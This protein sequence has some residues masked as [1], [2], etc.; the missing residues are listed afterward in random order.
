MNKQILYP[1]DNKSKRLLFSF[2]AKHGALTKYKWNRNIYLQK[3][4]CREVGDIM[5]T[6]KTYISRAFSWRLTPEGY[7]Y[8]EHLNQ[9]WYD[10]IRYYI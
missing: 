8:W 1:M 7:A 2:L 10:I 6:N 9:L 3:D 5:M 4:W